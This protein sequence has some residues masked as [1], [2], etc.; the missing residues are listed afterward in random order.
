MQELANTQKQLA[1]YDRQAL[2]YR[3]PATT[4]GFGWHGRFTTSGK[5]QIAKP[6]AEWTGLSSSGGKFPQK[7]D[8]RDLTDAE[9][10]YYET[11]FIP[12]YEALKRREQDL[13]TRLGAKD[14]STRLTSMARSANTPSPFAQNVRPSATLGS[15]TRVV[16]NQKFRK[17]G[18]DSWEAVE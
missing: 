6:E 2:N 5:M 11:R 8:Y 1:A 14:T 15:E 13:L 7:E 4:S 18:P 3:T 9:K 17:V 16:G 10:Q 12:E